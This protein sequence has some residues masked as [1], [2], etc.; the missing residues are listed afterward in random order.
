MALQPHWLDG[1]YKSGD[2]VDAVL[3]RL[4]ESKELKKA[5]EAGIAEEIEADK[6]RGKSG[7]SGPNV[8]QCVR[9][10]IQHAIE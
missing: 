2:S 9:G 3:K 4:S 10:Q 8:G 6:N 5:V 7:W 1:L